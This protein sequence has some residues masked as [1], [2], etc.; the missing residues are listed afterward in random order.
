MLGVGFGIGVGGSGSAQAFVNRVMA[1][2]GENVLSAGEVAALTSGFEDASWLYVPGARKAGKAYAQLP[3]SGAGDLAVAR[4]SLATERTRAGLLA[5]AAANVPRVDFLDGV[6]R[7]QPVQPLLINQFRN[8]ENATDPGQGS[9]TNVGFGTAAWA[10]SLGLAGVAQFVD[11]AVN[12]IYYNTASL[13]AGTYTIAFLARRSDGAPL[14]VTT[15]N[16]TS[17]IRPLFN[18]NVNA[19][20]PKTLQHIGNGVYFVVVTD[21]TLA[22]SA[23]F[24]MW[25]STNMINSNVEASAIMVVSGDVPL[26][27]FDYIR[28]TGAAQTRQAD[29][30]SLS[31]ASALIGQTEGTIFAEV[32][33]S[34]LLGLTTRGIITV[35]DGSSFN[36][37]QI[38][39][40]A[41][42]TNVIRV[43]HQGSSTATFDFSVLSTGL[44]KL[45]FAYS[46]NNTVFYVNG[47]LVS[48]SVGNS[49]LNSIS[50]I[51]TGSVFNDT[52]AFNDRIRRAALFTTRKSNEWLAERT[53]L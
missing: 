26:M 8:S 2:G 39:F 1:D 18:G 27:L 20:L 21:T 31:G 42:L 36:R 14:A 33:I 4:N 5:D 48:S 22:A 15:A 53:A 51:N 3:V 28:T 6:F 43:I 35:S 10:T 52:A 25:K 38:G 29:V 37:I 9:R 49:F 12:R 19:N 44:L 16:G 17:D 41:S 32:D 46:I 11:N 47:S 7:G 34:I 23:N 30:I 40:T 45:A 24:G 13:A 50:K